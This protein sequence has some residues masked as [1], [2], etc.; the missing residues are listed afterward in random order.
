MTV[1]SVSLFNFIGWNRTSQKQENRSEL[2]TPKPLIIYGGE[3][4]ILALLSLLTTPLLSKL[5]DIG[6]DT[7]WELFVY[8]WRLT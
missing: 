2:I 3:G 6:I 5:S 7:L 1:L 4:A 8:E